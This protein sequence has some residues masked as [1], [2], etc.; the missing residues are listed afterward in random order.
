M[1]YL[2]NAFTRRW[3]ARAAAVF[4]L[5]G[6]SLCLGGARHALTGRLDQQAAARWSG[7]GTPY[8]QVSVYFDSTTALSADTLQQKA[9]QIATSLTESSLEPAGENA[10]LWL[11]AASAEQ[12]ASATAER[13]STS[14][15]LLAVSGDY[16]FFHPMWMLSGSAFG[17]S[18][19]HNDT[20]VLDS[21]AAWQLFGSNDVVGRS[22]TIDGLSYVVCGVAKAPVDDAAGA[23]TYGETPRAWVQS[24]RLHKADEALLTCYE[25]VL[26]NPYGGYARG[27]V[28]DTFSAADGGC[29]VVE[30]SR[31]YGLAG[32]WQTFTGF[33]RAALRQQAVAYPWWENAALYCQSRAA[34]LFFAQALCMLYP[35]GLAVVGAVW[36]VRHRP[37]HFRD[38]LALIE[39]RRQRRLLAAW[40][41]AAHPDAL[42]EM[43]EDDPFADE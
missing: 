4:L 38:L 7:D 25:A 34:L 40:D 26:P 19:E 20:V 39:R 31:R 2:V 27:L 36:C 29:V 16:F 30:N 15:Q 1:R 28:E 13:G 32:L 23:L 8:A 41:A 22:V 33:P 10:R 35:L 5:V 9:D 6:I 24:A 43:A 11:S 3:L 21:L 42:T 18:E 37:W 17:A 12:P 14:L